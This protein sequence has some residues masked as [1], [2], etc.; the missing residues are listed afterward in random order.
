MRSSLLIADSLHNRTLS[1]LIQPIQLLHILVIK[2]ESIH[3]SIAHDPR[4]CVAFRQRYISLLQTPSYKHLIRAHVVFLADTQECLVLRFFIPNERA[5]RFDDDIVVL[6]V[7]D[8]FALLAP[9]ME[10]YTQD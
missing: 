9:G 8:D 7:F 3:I 6:A 2:L 4:R 10:L 1:T 5:V